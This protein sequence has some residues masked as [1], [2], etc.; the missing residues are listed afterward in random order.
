MKQWLFYHSIL[1]LIGL[2]NQLIGLIFHVVKALYFSDFQHDRCI[3]IW[4]KV[5]CH[6]IV[7]FSSLTLWTQRCYYCDNINVYAHLYIKG[8]ISHLTAST[9]NSLCIL[10]E[11]ILRSN[12][13]GEVVCP[14]DPDWNAGCFYRVRLFNCDQVLDNHPYGH[15]WHLKYFINK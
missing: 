10:L 12:I 9:P 4:N 14:G 2:Y 6:N 15:N 13:T 11:D 3:L 8:C 7:R 1:I 5:V